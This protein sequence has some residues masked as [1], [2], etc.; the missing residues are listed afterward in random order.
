MFVLF[1][2]NAERLFQRGILEV[3]ALPKDHPITFRYQKKYVTSL[4][5]DSLERESIGDLLKT[6]GTQALIIYAEKPTEDC[7]SYQYC[8]VRFAQISS[9]RVLGDIVF[10]EMV[11][12]ECANLI[13][14][15][16]ETSEKRE[17]F[18]RAVRE[19]AGALI[20]ST[21]VGYFLDLID[22]CS[23]GLWSDEQTEGEV[24]QTVVDRLAVMPSMQNCLFYRVRG[25]YT[26]IAGS[27]FRKALSEKTVVPKLSPHSLVYP[28][29]MSEAVDL[30]LLFYRP[31]GAVPKTIR[32]TLEVE[33]DKSGFSEVP[34]KRILL[35]SRYDEIS[36]RL[37]TK[38]VFDN[39]LAPVS[40]R[41]KESTPPDVLV[42]EP[43]LL[44]VVRVP[45]R[46]LILVIAS[47]FLGPIL[48][49]L[50][51]DDV[52]WILSRLPA[53]TRVLDISDPT[54]ASM[55]LA[56]YLKLFGGLIAAAAGFII[57]RRLPV[58][59]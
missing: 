30:K 54:S 2:S 40:I 20:A 19:R 9:L 25:Y 38:R 16:D 51:G 47:L 56:V 50:T 49:S 33:A 4:V 24:W 34:D 22:D 5:G 41:L 36:I 53:L 42:S 57:F 7:D 29:P 17:M 27:L 12:R 6:W 21:G 39:T 55:R 14:W 1:S 3:L 58:S 18:L 28:I 45:S 35:E 43:L 48:L 8:P 15:D 32:A 11:L 52:A 46:L 44:C 37:A 59:K 10:V 31:S 26:S 13:H 23:W